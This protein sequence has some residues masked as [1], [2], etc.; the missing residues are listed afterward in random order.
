MT[1][2]WPSW[3]PDWEQPAF[4]QFVDFGDDIREKIGKSSYTDI[5][6]ISG[7]R[8]DLVDREVGEYVDLTHIEDYPETAIRLQALLRSLEHEYDDRYLACTFANKN[9]AIPLDSVCITNLVSEY[10]TFMDK[11]FLPGMDL[12]QKPQLVLDSEP[13]FEPSAIK[14]FHQ[15]LND[16]VDRILFITSKG[17]LGLGPAITL[18][19]DVVVVLHGAPVPFVL[20]PNEDLWEFVGESYLYVINEGRIHR[21][22]EE[23]GSVSEK[24]CLW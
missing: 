10:R 22:W 11:E 3:V 14:F 5:S 2:N 17:M 8:V 24:F 13:P 21:E 23:N 1:N 4:T 7:Y 20:R 12:V 9:K 6:E 15:Y 19:G 16:E 18:P